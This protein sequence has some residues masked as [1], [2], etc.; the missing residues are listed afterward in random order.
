MDYT[1]LLQKIKT[2]WEQQLPFVI[3]ATPQ[4]TKAHVLLQQDS[5]S[6]SAKN[7]SN[8]GFV[9][10]PFDNTN[11]WFCIP[12][13]F[14]EK[15]SLELHG[16]SVLNTNTP[17]FQELV[18]DKEKHLVY[19]SEI[20]DNI[21]NKTVE[22]VVAT[23]KKEISLTSFDIS[24]LIKCI[25]SQ[26]ISAFRYV[27]YHPKT[28]IWCGASPEVL[29]ERDGVNF[30]TM[31]LAGTQKVTGDTTTTWGSKEIFEQQLVTQAITTNLKKITTSLHVSSPKTHKAGSLYHIKTQIKGVFDN[32]QTTLA[33]ITSVLHP[34]PAVC[35]SPRDTAFSIIQQ[36]EAYDREF[37]TG[38]LGPLDTKK[39]TAQIYVNLRCMKIS[40]TKATL[41]VGGGITLD[42]NP[43]QE[44]QETKNKMATMLSVLAPM[45]Q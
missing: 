10:A 5:S 21:K 16:P 12:E 45:V 36:L 17:F 32:K 26:D 9:F 4:Q 3:Y 27:W 14:S 25:I 23:R 33:Q 6:H 22:K 28:G 24:E 31:A 38:F 34:T 30:S 35:G 40:P 39:N 1:T 18:S 41:F 2:H 13:A 37:Y 15:I 29:L 20:L 19:V 43:E 8:T 42:S 7:F 11:T 44:W